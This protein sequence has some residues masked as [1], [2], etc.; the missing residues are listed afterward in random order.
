MS[1][2]KSRLI[3]WTTW[4]A[5]QSP[6]VTNDL[7][8]YSHWKGRKLPSICTLLTKCRLYKNIYVYAYHISTLTSR[9]CCDCCSGE[10]IYRTHNDRDMDGHYREFAYGYSAL[11]WSKRQHC[12]ICTYGV[13]CRRGAQCG[14]EDWSQWWSFYHR[15][16]KYAHQ[17]V[18]G[19]ASCVS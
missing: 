19:F 3:V 4:C 10:R 16:G 5:L 15:Y 18:H 11:Q 7:S 1:Q 9:E 13:E 2:L 14:C 17:P 6:L 12:I 8:Q